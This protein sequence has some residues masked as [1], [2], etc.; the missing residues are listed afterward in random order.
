MPGD[1]EECRANARQCMDLA[2]GVK[3][4]ELTATFW[5]L[6]NKWTKIATELEKPRKPPRRPAS[7]TRTKK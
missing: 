7:K 5:A 6:A 3:Y 4:P 1:P 2:A